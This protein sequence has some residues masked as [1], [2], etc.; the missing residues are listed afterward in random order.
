MK[1]TVLNVSH[2]NY[3]LLCFRDIVALT[4]TYI[5]KIHDQIRVQMEN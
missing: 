4:V 5:V 1:V 3:S 2:N